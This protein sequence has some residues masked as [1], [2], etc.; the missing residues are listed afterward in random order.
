VAQS[1]GSPARALQP[2]DTVSI[3]PGEEHWH[4]PVPDCLMTHL[5]I[6]EADEQWTHAVWVDHVTD[7]GQRAELVP[8]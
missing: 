4:D 7:D 2:G 6:R 1:R 8:A 5:A 3:P